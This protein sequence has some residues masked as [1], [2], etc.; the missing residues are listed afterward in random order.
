MTRTS[1]SRRLTCHLG[2][3]AIR[4]HYKNHHQ[5]TLTRQ[6]LEKGTEIID[7]EKEPRRLRILEALHILENNPEINCQ[8]RDLQIIPTMKKRQQ[9]GLTQ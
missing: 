7:R 9:H 2:T 4:E 8:V 5:T 6:Q 3:G 1:L